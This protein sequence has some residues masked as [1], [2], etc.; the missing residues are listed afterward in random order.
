MV[1]IVLFSARFLLSL[2][3]PQYSHVLGANYLDIVPKTGLRSY[4]RVNNGREGCSSQTLHFWNALLS[5]TRPR[6]LS[7]NTFLLTIMFVR[8]DI[9]VIVETFAFWQNRAA[10][11][12]R[13]HALCEFNALYG[14][15]VSSDEI[16]E[17]TINTACINIYQ[18]SSI[19]D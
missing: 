16:P 12:K 18:V 10:L 17:P 14:T 11:N 13:S 19:Y 1:R 5:V 15:G 7:E 2:L 4:N 3:G 6:D 9:I 8:Y